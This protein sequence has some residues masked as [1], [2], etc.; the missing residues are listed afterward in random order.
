MIEIQELPVASPARRPRWVLPVVVAAVALAGVGVG[1]AFANRSDTP[2]P[3]AAISSELTDIGRAC[4]TWMNNDAH[5][6]P[7]S[8]D[9]CR[10][11]T[12]W[13]GEQMT[14][15]S[16]TGSM[17]W[18]DVDRMLSTCRAWMDSEPS[19]GVPAEWCES[20]IGGMWPHMNGDWEGWDER[21]NGPM[22]GG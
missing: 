6:G 16:M 10:S 18:T 3:A 21:M 22:M 7:T 8:A 17:M 15:G 1:T 5:W 14:T 2:R 9:W 19:T 20:M 12:G 4:T 11:M 13:M